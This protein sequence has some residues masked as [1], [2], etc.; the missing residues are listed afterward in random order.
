MSCQGS[1]RFDTTCVH[2][3]YM[4]NEPVS[5]KKMYVRAVLPE[6][7]AFFYTLFIC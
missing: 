6:S 2:R 7:N 4:D 5:Q 1:G 3:R